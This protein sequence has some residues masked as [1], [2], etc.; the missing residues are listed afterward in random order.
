MRTLSRTQAPSLWDAPAVVRVAAWTDQLVDT[1]ISGFCATDFDEL[2]HA[3]STMSY[4]TPCSLSKNVDISN[5]RGQMRMNLYGRF[6]NGS[7]YSL[8]QASTVDPQVPRLLPS[9]PTPTLDVI[10]PSP[11]TKR[12]RPLPP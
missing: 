12:L 5:G 7:S 8:D 6:V 2:S 11:D 1:T 9:I 4:A 3:L 10:G